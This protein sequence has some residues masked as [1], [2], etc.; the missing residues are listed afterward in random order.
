MNQKRRTLRFLHI[1]PYC[2]CSSRHTKYIQD[3]YRHRLVL[4]GTVFKN[5]LMNR[6][7]LPLLCLPLLLSACG[8]STSSNNGLTPLPDYQG[9]DDSALI[10]AVNEFIQAR[11]AP[12]N[13]EYDFV[14]IDLNGDG[15]RDAIVLFKLPH[16]YWCGWDG[17]GM[18]VFRA[19]REH[20]TP[21]ATISNVRGPIYVNS[22]G[23]KGWRDIIIRLSGTTMRDK[24]VTLAFDGHTYPQSPM[25]AKT[26]HIPLSSLS[27]EKFFR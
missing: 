4:H 17:C 18:A 19:H 6:F 3:S 7:L 26:L 9:P 12:P 24:N 15:L 10:E 2:Q 11:T 1:E 20:F 14:R 16:T 23:N 27:T 22:T 8:G 5:T 13:S 25:L 21:L